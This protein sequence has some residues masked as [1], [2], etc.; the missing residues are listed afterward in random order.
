MQTLTTKLVK[1]GL[2]LKEKEVQVIRNSIAE[3]L[4]DIIEA[5]DTFNLSDADKEAIWNFTNELEKRVK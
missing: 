4:D 1:K 3:L 2:Y 5:L